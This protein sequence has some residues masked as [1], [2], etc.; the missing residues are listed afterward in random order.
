MPE[1]PKI[2]VILPAYNVACYVGDA[3]RSI[4][5]QSYNDFELIIIDDCSTD[6]TVSVIQ[7]FN[8]DRI[9][10]IKKV[11]NTGYT[12]SLNYGISI[13]Q[14]EYIARMDGDDVSMSNR[15]EEQVKILDNYKDIAVCGSFAKILGS[16]VIMKVPKDHHTIVSKMILKNQII[17]PVVMIRKKVLLDNSLSYDSK[18]EPAEDYELW[19]R[20]LNFGNLHNIQKPLLQYRVHD[21][22]ISKVKNFT[23]RKSA[24][25]VKFNLFQ[26]LGF[27]S[28]KDSLFLWEKFID[29]SAAFTDDEFKKI[30]IFFS[31]FFENSK[32]DQS[33]KVKIR[34]L[35]GDLL[36][37]KKSKFYYQKKRFNLKLLRSFWFDNSISKWGYN[38]KLTLKFILKCLFQ[39]ESKYYE[40]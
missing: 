25:E 21:G 16:E 29:L 10:L 15:F 12:N 17:H 36:A 9:K 11:K 22:Q 20:I 32:I 24:L 34:K 4:L 35:Y 37:D 40:K 8:D 31:N 3:I 18:F 19:S 38:T 39:F 26:Y 6:S 7:S 27:N 23:Q 28:S 13:A 33:I 2:S 30:S 14:G 5:N 1:L